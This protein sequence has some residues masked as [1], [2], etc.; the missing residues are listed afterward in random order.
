M[1][2]EL[3]ESILLILLVLVSLA[4]IGLVL[5]QQGK[6]A[7]AGAAFG[8]GGA[9]SVFGAVGP[10]NFLQRLTTWL[11]VLFFAITF[12]LAYIA[13][14]RA[15]GEEN[16]ALPEAP[17][18][19]STEAGGADEP[20]GGLMDLDIPQVGS[21]PADGTETTPEEVPTVD[22]DVDLELDGSS[23]AVESEPD[24]R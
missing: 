1:T 16:F 12:G 19:A 5:L 20:F 14:E 4:L 13:S 22:V 17:E 21:D 2:L 9:N 24:D 11:A 7:N 18:D 6:G 8:G 10:A 3:I 15:R 23:D